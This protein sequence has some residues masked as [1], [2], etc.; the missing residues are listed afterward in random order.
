MD[1]ETLPY[2]DHLQS[3]P[4]EHALWWFIE[5]VTADDPHRT[6]YFFLLRERFRNEAQ[7]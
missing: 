7:S 6:D 2:A 4:L 5:N 3:L 1:E